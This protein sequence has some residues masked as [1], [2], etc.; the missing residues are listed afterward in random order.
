MFKQWC[1]LEL[2]GH[3]TLAG[4]V[5]EEEHFGTKL[6]RI[7]IPTSDTEF[8]TQYFGGSSVYRATPCTEEIARSLAKTLNYQPPHAWSVRHELL[9]IEQKQTDDP[10]D[11]EDDNQDIE[12]IF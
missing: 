12:E 7:D 10:D 8:L 11:S 5:T 4:L 9:Q 1:L 6:G 2:M 3:S